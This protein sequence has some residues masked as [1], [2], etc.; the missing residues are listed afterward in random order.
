MK[1]Q[2]IITL[3]S[4]P[5]DIDSEEEI[6]DYMM[7]IKDEYEN[8]DDEL[9]VWL[10]QGANYSTRTPHIQNA[11]NAHIQADFVATMIDF[12]NEPTWYNNDLTDE[13]EH[14]GVSKYKDKILS[15][16]EELRDGD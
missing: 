8:D 10:V 4:I 1:A 11:I 16:M 12:A 15:L 5:V 13:L 9:Y 2:T 6:I 3:M 7:Q 14:Y